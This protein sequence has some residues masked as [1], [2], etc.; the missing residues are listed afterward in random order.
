MEKASLKSKEELSKEKTKILQEVV[1]N[2][3]RKKNKERVNILRVALDE[4]PEERVIELES[5]E[6]KKGD[7]MPEELKEKLKTSE[8]NA[9]E[10]EAVAEEKINKYQKEGEKRAVKLQK[11]AESAKMLEPKLK[12]MR[13]EIL[14]GKKGEAGTVAEIKKNLEASEAEWDRIG[15]DLDWRAREEEARQILGEDGIRAIERL[16]SEEEKK[17][18]E[19][20]EADFENIPYVKRKAT[21]ERLAGKMKK[22]GEDYEKEEREK[23][24]EKQKEEFEKILEGKVKEAQEPKE[25][26]LSDLFKKDSVE[27]GFELTK[28]K[29]SEAEAKKEK[30]SLTELDDRVN[31]LWKVMD[32]IL[33][34]AAAYKPT[35]TERKAMGRWAKK[36]GSVED[37]PLDDVVTAENYKERLK[38]YGIADFIDPSAIEPHNDAYAV[39]SKQY[40]KYREELEKRVRHAKLRQL[41]Q[42]EEGEESSRPVIAKSETERRTSPVIARS[43]ARRNDEAISSKEE[44]IDVTDDTIE[45]EVSFEEETKKEQPNSEVYKNEA[46]AIAQR[47]SLRWVQLKEKVEDNPSILTL[48]ATF[49]KIYEMTQPPVTGIQRYFESN[50]KFI[51][52]QAGDNED[53][54]S[55]MMHRLKEDMERIEEKVNNIIDEE[56]FKESEFEK[57]GEE[58][59]IKEKEQKTIK[60]G[61]KKLNKDLEKKENTQTA[62]IKKPK[63]KK[64]VFGWFSSLFKK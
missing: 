47:I 20:N 44:Q 16:Q 32:A 37:W 19:K 23:K 18:T 12:K 21:K 28:K 40:K 59:T 57:S 64:G 24:E 8:E 25:E 17:E 53:A 51:E 45:E 26:D 6:P 10:A 52:E 13:E 42:L 1:D 48:N 60:K 61:Q 54:K 2:E 5:E 56:K 49:E 14:F 58:E 4:E 31:E 9:M 62:V 46:M 30:L 33:Q 50:V 15:E 3:K 27:E 55:R 63:K 41:E 22:V 35:K 36:G 34:D 7:V 43:E 39:V 38:K 11:A 29:T